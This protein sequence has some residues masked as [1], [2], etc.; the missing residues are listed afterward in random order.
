MTKQIHHVGLA[1]KSIEPVAKFWEEVFGAEMT[2]YKMETPEF[3]SRIMAVGKG[4]FEL[5]E[6]RG[7][8]GLI[9][10]F[11]NTNGEGIH[12]VSVMVDDV[13]EVLATCKEKGMKTIF[14]R[15]IHPKSAHGVLIELIDKDGA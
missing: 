5:L 6:P 12:H 9:E 8:N 10:R 11:L 14:N 4:L 2:D 1:V 13:D 3:F 7:E 15:F